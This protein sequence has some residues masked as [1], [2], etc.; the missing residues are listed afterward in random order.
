M[1]ES[2]E[3]YGKWGKFNMKSLGTQDRWV[4]PDKKEGPD[5]H[6][7]TVGRQDAFNSM[8]N[9]LL[10]HQQEIVKVPACSTLES[11]T[12]WCRARPKSGY[13]PGLAHLNDDRRYGKMVSWGKTPSAHSYRVFTFK[14][15]PHDTSYWYSLIEGFCSRFLLPD[16]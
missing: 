8:I 9:L 5:T 16:R 4:D 2:N 7:I 15:R 13:R 12:E 10:N 14:S 6:G 1:Q 3:Q 11:A